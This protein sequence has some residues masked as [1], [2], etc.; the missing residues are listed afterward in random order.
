MFLPCSMRTP[1]SIRGCGGLGKDLT[2]EER[3]KALVGNL[4][5]IL[6]GDALVCVARVI[7]TIISVSEI[8]TA[9]A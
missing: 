3:Q 9:S 8:V 1:S 5:R 4:I 6:S 7:R 2:A